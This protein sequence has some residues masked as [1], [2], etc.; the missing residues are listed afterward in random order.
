MPGR[1]SSQLLHYMRRL[2]TTHESGLEPRSPRLGTAIIFLPTTDPLPLPLLSPD[3]FLIDTHP[4]RDLTQFIH[5]TFFLRYVQLSCQKTALWKIV[6]LFFENFI[7]CYQSCFMKEK[8]LFFR[9]KILIL[10][11]I[12]FLMFFVIGIFLTTQR[13][14]V[15]FKAMYQSDHVT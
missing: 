13:K 2:C 11:K 7:L 15:V 12:I 6:F 10:R 1:Q 8:T 9:K 3:S 4:V 5:F 14:K